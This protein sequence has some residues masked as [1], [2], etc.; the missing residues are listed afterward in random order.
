MTFG[1]VFGRTFS[2][3]FQPKSQAAAS[4]ANGWWDLDGTITSCVAAY[5]PKGAASLAASYDNLTGNATYDCVA[6]SAPSLDANGW[7]GA[8]AYLKTGVVPQANYTMIARISSHN[9]KDVGIIIGCVASGNNFYFK[10]GSTTNNMAFCNGTNEVEWAQGTYVISNGIYAIAGSNGYYGGTA[11][12]ATLDNTWGTNTNDIWLMKA[13]SNG[14]PVGKFSP[15]WAGDRFMAF[16]VYNAT[17]TSTQIGNLTTAMA[18][19]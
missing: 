5:Q 19:L 9:H 7:Y 18:A 6:G 4:A 1:S 2:P 10:M 16:A 14:T 3:T 12:V 8:S 11:K 17:L 15:Y 13:N